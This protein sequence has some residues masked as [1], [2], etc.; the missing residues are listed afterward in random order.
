MDAVAEVSDGSPLWGHGTPSR[1]SPGRPIVQETRDLRADSQRAPR[2]AI[3]VFWEYMQPTI[4]VLRERGGSATVQELVGQVPAR[5]ALSKEQLSVPHDPAGGPQSEVAYRMAWA[6]TFLKR[7][8]LI[9]NSDRGVWTLTQEGQTREEIDGQAIAREM[10]GERGG[11]V[12]GAPNN[13]KSE[14]YLLAW[15]PERFSWDALD[16]QIR[17]V[18]DTGSAD[19]QWSCG[20]VKSIPPGSRFFLI[21]LG[22]E[23]RGIVGSGVTV[24]EVREAAHWNDGRASQ[25]ETTRFVDIRFD[26]LSRTPLIGRSDLGQ[27]P[28]DGFRWDTQMSGIRIPDELAEKLESEWQRRLMARARGESPAVLQKDVIDRWRDFWEAAGADAAWLERHGLR[29]AKRREALPQIRDLIA[30]F[31]N[32]DVSLVA[33]RDTFDRKTRNEWD[34]FGLKGLSGAM[35]LNKLAKHLPDKE[36]VADEL[37]RALQVPASEADAREK[38]N[39]FMEYLERQIEAGVATG[40]GLQPNRAPF[41]V[42]ACWH[43]QQPEE[44]PIM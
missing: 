5:M 18:R 14:T 27:P 15:N 12:S 10:R 38:I 41:F 21:R 9:D 19:D 24:D 25:G 35:F 23:P 36:E 16:D 7:A 43:A 26:T 29:D 34:L 17:A 20:Q 40:A 31:V 6:R 32:G 42:S 39:A 44:W 22:N 37:R 11:S 28:F 2:L 30:G 4:E 8:G 13:E 33:F 3:P 1:T